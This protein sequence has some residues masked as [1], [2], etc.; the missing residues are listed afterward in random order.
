M[1]FKTLEKKRH[2]LFMETIMLSWKFLRP[3]TLVR[4]PMFLVYSIVG[5]LHVP[6]K[7]LLQ[8]G[9]TPTHKLL[10]Y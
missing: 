3:I 7:D 2:L 10:T 5:N 6:S 9:T 4:A 1:V 8:C